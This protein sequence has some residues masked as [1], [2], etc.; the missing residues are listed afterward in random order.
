M[1]MDAAQLS[2]VTPGFAQPVQGAQSVFRQLLEAMS[3]PGRVLRLPSA[4]LQGLRA[5]SARGTTMGPGMAALLLTLLDGETT[6][7]LGGTLATPQAIAF[8]RFHTGVSLAEPPESAA[9]SAWRHGDVS[10]ALWCRLDDGSDESPQS[11]AT[12]LI[13]V[14]SL[15]AGDVA[16]SG[17]ACTLRLRGP[18]IETTHRLAIGGL[19]ADFWHQRIAMQP[20]FPRGVDL[21]LCCDEMV[22]AI[23]RSTCVQ[24]EGQ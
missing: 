4:A 2:D 22:A 12:L 15:V 16:P 11:G 1:I 6:L 19:D 21:V 18:G 10:A 7:Q 24:L 9:F 8:C 13:E 23:P 20:R 3:R 17:R 5:P 14:A